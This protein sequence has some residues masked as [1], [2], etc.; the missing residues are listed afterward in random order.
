MNML[1]KTKIMRLMLK[2]IPEKQERRGG[3]GGGGGGVGTHQFYTSHNYVFHAEA[4]T[5]IYPNK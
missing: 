2:A 5:M 1:N 4:P 3:G